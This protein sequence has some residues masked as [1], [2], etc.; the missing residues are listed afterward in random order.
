MPLTIEVVRDR[1]ELLRRREAWT[2]LVDRAGADLFHTYEWITTWLA[3]FGRDK[4][5][6]FRFIWEEDGLAGLAPFVEDPEGTLWCR[7]TL[8]SPVD[9]DSYRTAFIAAGDGKAAAAALFRH[10][11]ETHPRTPIVLNKADA[12]TDR[13]REFAAVARRFGRKAVPVGQNASPTLRL[14]GSWEEFLKSKPPHFRSELRRKRKRLEASAAAVEVLVRSPDEF[15]SAFD[16]VLAVERASWKHGAGTSFA[17]GAASAGFYRSFGAQAAENGWLRLRLLYLDGRPAAHVFALARKGEFLA[18]KTSYD[19]ARK[20][21][22]PGSVLVESVV[23]EAFREQGKT[24]DF[25]GVE[26]RWKNAYADSLRPY[27]TLCLFPKSSWRCWK[28]L[29]YE[30]RLRPF[31]RRRLPWVGAVKRRLSRRSASD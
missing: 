4:P 19:E 12:S 24:F 20:A 27:V 16:D 13:W 14:E 26:S 21:L 18:L 10:L 30:G 23:R 3:W 9:D 11:G 5:L 1:S 29:A 22:S 2:S 31:I 17:A 6:A 15:A 7:R 8:A 28:C 25:L